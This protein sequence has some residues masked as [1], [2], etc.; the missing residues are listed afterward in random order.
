MQ[1]EALQLSELALIQARTQMEFFYKTLT[2]GDTSTH[3]LPWAS[4]HR[5][6]FTFA[7]NS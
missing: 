4:P 6:L 7:I 2:V 1:K 5:D 3:I